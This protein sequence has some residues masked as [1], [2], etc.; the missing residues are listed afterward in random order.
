MAYKK[1]FYSY[2]NL[3]DAKMQAFMAGYDV[4]GATMNN[5]GQYVVFARQRQFAW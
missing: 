2:K 3:D 4:I 5:K 1:A